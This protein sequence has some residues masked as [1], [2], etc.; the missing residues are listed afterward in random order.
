MKQAFD[1]KKPFT[2]STLNVACK[3]IQD[4]RIV[5]LCRN[6]IKKMVVCRL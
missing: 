6:T 2:F 5:I 4:C 3:Q 1:K